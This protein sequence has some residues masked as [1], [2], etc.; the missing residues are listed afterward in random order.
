ML[1]RRSVQTIVS[2]VVGMVL[3]F[4]AVMPMPVIAAG[5]TAERTTAEAAAQAEVAT[6]SPTPS[7]AATEDQ[8]TSTEPE[9][10]TPVV[11]EPAPSETASP[12]PTVDPTQPKLSLTAEPLYVEAGDEA[13]IAWVVE[14]ARK[15]TRLT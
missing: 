9:V 15:Q 6:P 8:P 11:A 14:G 4:N 5:E 7:E 12:A 10:A 1:Q 3:L 13:K 2:T